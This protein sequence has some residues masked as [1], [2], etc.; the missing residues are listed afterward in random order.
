MTDAEAKLFMTH[1]FKNIRGSV[2][3]NSAEFLAQI[4]NL[5]HVNLSLKKFA[6]ISTDKLG[7]LIGKYINYFNGPADIN[8][9]L[10][11]MDA[12][13]KLTKDEN[14]IERIVKERPRVKSDLVNGKTMDE[15]VKD[16]VDKIKPAAR[17]APAEVLEGEIKTVASYLSKNRYINK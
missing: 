6:S 12:I 16:I 14:V 17:A 1:L 8:E 5:T 4:E 11:R 2:G 15:I 10:A 9:F 7:A 3:K 13:D